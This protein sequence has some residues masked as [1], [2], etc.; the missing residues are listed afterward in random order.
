MSGEEVKINV[1]VSRMLYNLEYKA[2]IERKAE[3]RKSRDEREKKVK[4][5]DEGKK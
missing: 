3:S 2:L 4:E 1:E 5:E